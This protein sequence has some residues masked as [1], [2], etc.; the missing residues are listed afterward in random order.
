VHNQKFHKGTKHIDVEFHIIHEHEHQ[1]LGTINIAYI[2]TND[3][4]SNILTKALMTK[5]FQHMRSLLGLTN[6]YAK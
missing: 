3:H 5:K 1:L 6:V 4:K 2:G